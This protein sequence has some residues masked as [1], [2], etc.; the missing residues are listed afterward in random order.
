MKLLAAIV[1]FATIAVGDGYNCAFAKPGCCSHHNGVCGCNRA[2][3][4]QRCCDGTDSPS[5]RCGE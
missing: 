4:M 5:C 2:T 1:M 3:G